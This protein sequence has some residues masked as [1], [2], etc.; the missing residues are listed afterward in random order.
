MQ[1]W[2]ECSSCNQ[3][4]HGYQLGKTVPAEN[5]LSLS[6]QYMHAVITHHAEQKG[7]TNGPER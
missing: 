5:E 7:W 2:T 3:A 1:S 4:A 6:A